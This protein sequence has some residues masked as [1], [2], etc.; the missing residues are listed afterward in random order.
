MS[1][2]WAFTASKSASLSLTVALD[3]P[4]LQRKLGRQTV[5]LFEQ[6]VEDGHRRATSRQGSGQA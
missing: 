2:E 4:T 5:N 6:T 1:G 3:E